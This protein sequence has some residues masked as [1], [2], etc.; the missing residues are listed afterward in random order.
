[1]DQIRLMKQLAEILKRQ[2]FTNITLDFSSVV[3]K[4]ANTD[5]VPHTTS[6]SCGEIYL[7]GEPNSLIKVNYTPRTITWENGAAPFLQEELAFSNNGAYW[8]TNVRKKGPINAMSPRNT[9]EITEKCPAGFQSPRLNGVEQFLVSHAIFFGRSTLREE[10]D[11]VLSVPA[12]TLPQI[13]KDYSI[14]KKGD[15]LIISCRACN[16]ISPG[17]SI[18]A[19]MSIDLSKGGALKNWRCE[20]TSGSKGNE[21]TVEV[22]VDE[23]TNVNGLWFPT[24]ASRNFQDA[25]GQV[26][27]E[28][29]AK[30]YAIRND[31]EHLYDIPLT[32]GTQVVDKRTGIN[33][34]V[35]RTIEDT[36]KAIKAGIK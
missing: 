9:A 10:L 15:L 19:E 13:L 16:P 12:E 22:T 21:S 7:S 11:R 4:K 18:S 30:N 5:S 25:K 6:W 27:V 29:A 1:M 35:G 2:V 36:Q 23:Y 3:S 33:F 28:F 26:K 8:T 14:K 34:V 20:T 32:P 17:D 31:S 24:K